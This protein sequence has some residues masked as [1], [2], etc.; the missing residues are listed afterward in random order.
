MMIWSGPGLSR[1]GSKVKSYVSAEAFGKLVAVAARGS[2]QSLNT[3]YKW[4]Q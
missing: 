1:N 2:D 4:T 3:M